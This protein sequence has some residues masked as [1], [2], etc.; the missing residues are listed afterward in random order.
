[1]I[2]HMEFYIFEVTA[3]EFLQFVAE[4]MLVHSPMKDEE[5]KLAPDGEK[6]TFVLASRQGK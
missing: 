1:M 2:P 3:H 6:G 5:R 4:N